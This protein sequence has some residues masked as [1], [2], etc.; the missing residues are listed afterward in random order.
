MSTHFCVVT[1][2]IVTPGHDRLSFVSF[3]R[4]RRFFR[5]G[6]GDPREQLIVC[7]DMFFLLSASLGMQCR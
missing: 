4:F 3:P 2:H 6:T 5:I 7:L 1:F